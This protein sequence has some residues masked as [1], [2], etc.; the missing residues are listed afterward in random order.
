LI[1]RSYRGERK[2][3]VLLHGRDVAEMEIAEM[4]QVVGTLLQDPERQIVA[5]NVFNEIAFGP[6]NLGLPRE[7]IIFRVEQVIKRF[8]EAQKTDKGF[9]VGNFSP[10]LGKNIG[11]CGCFM[12]WSEAGHKGI[13]AIIQACC[14]HTGVNY[15]NDP[16]HVVYAHQFIAKKSVWIDYVNT[17]LIPSIELMETELWET[18]NQDAGYTL[19]MKKEA[20]KAA[21]GLDFYNY[22]PFVCE[23]LFMQFIHHRNLNTI[24]LI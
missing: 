23:R 4:S 7:E 5:S 21:T 15:E 18:V 20:L 2:G 19:A 12:D 14:A 11:G 3:K 1:P 24:Q 6:E 17:V 13:K 22:L 10:Q 16:Q 9:D 8:I